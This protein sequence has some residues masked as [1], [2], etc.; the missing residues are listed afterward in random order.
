MRATYGCAVRSRSSA[1]PGVPPAPPGPS[2]PELGRRGIR[3][4]VGQLR[5]S[6]GVDEM[7]D[8]VV[9]P[10]GVGPPARVARGS[11]R[12]PGDSPRILRTPGREIAMISY[13]SQEVTA[14]LSG[15]W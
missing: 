12:R 4:V 10:S 7:A 14:V 8:G 3:L 13:D 5:M 11:R 1:T 2:P 9:G 15:L 6:D